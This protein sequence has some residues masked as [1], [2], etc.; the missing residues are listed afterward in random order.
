MNKLYIPALIALS[1]LFSSCNFNS[2][3]MYRTKKDYVFATPPSNPEL[4]YKIVPNDILDFRLYTNDGFKLIDLYS[5]DNNR[6]MNTASDAFT[7]RVEFDGQVK[8]PIIG[9]VDIKGKTLREAEF[10]LQ[11]LYTKYYISPFVILNVTNKRILVF[12]GNGGAAKV[13][14]ME[15]NN[16]TLVEGVALA[17][18]ITENGKAK[19]VKLIRG[20]SK[21]QQVFLFNLNTL[22]GIEAANILLQPNDVIYI[23]PRSNTVRQAVREASPVISLL[24]SV[25]TLYLVITRL[26]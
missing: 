10:L 8:L 12:P 15:N 20:E 4:E 16:I 13:I 14:P 17:G 6:I 3:R 25:V 26:N 22:E 24:V 11:D 18:G 9:R 2:S 19:Q 7:Y 23:E 5:I 21:N 1:F